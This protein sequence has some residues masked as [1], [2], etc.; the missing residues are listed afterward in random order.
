MKIEVDST[1]CPVLLL[2]L[3]DSFDNSTHVTWVAINLANLKECHLYAV[4]QTDKS[5][6]CLP[7]MIA[8]VVL[9][10]HPSSPYI[11]L[12]SSELLSW[13]P[14]IDAKLIFIPKL[15]ETFWVVTQGS[16]MNLHEWNSLLQLIA[17]QHLSLTV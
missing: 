10:L 13:L 7:Y 14:F 12:L 4:T 3:Y 15:S 9:L 17:L 16:W 5:I 11:T 1:S 8:S 2:V 6:N